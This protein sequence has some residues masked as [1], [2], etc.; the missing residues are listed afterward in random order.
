MVPQDKVICVACHHTSGRRNPGS[1]LLLKDAFREQVPTFLLCHLQHMTFVLIATRW[2]QLLQAG[3]T[4]QRQKPFLWEFKK[5]KIRKGMSFLGTSFYI[6][7]AEAEPHG[8]TQLHERLR[9]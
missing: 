5:K 8:N 4:R 9:R 7:M 3:R 2:L 1:V 6:S